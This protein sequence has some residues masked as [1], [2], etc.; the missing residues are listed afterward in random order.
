VA[1]HQGDCG[2]AANLGIAGVD[3]LKQD[4]VGAVTQ[5]NWP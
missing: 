5:K 1:T 4:S 3:W 2:V